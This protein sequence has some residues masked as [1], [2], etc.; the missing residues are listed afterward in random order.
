MEE[1]TLNA[2]TEQTGVENESV[3][4]VQESLE[5][6]E[7]PHVTGQETQEGKETG[8]IETE[9][10][11]VD[12]RAFAARLRQEREKWEKENGDK[13]KF[14]KELEAAGYDLNTLQQELKKKDIDEMIAQG[15]DP[16]IA[17]EVVESR[18]RA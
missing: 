6:Q 7:G 4:G 5:T 3:A 18:S 13:I 17:K 1:T 2:Q 11:K 9:T 15:W 16:E 8:K 12:E 14:A 10:G